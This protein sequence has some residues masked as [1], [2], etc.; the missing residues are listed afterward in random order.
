MDK[1]ELLQ[2]L[3]DWLATAEQAD[4]WYDKDLVEGAVDLIDKVIDYM[5]D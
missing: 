5:T 1:Q 3:K 2:G 4:S